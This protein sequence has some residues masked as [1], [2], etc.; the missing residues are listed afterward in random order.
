MST[1]DKIAAQRAKNKGFVTYQLP[2]DNCKVILEDG[3]VVRSVDSIIEVGTDS[4]PYLQ[5]HLD[6]MVRCGNAVL[7]TQS[8]DVDTNAE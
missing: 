5:S 3:T 4:H 7:V 2:S 8:S 6:A 1:A